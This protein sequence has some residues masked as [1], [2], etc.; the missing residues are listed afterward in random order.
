MRLCNMLLRIPV[1]F[2]LSF[3]VYLILL[4]IVI[5]YVLF[6]ALALPK[7]YSW[8]QE[9]KIFYLA[10]HHRSFPGYLCFDGILTFF[11]LSYYPNRR[12]EKSRWDLYPEE[13]YELTRDLI[14][15]RLLIGKSRPAVRELLGK[16]A[17]LLD[18]TDEW[19]FDL[20]Y[21]PEIGNIDPSVL[22]VIFKNNLVVRAEQIR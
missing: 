20:G 9:E 16:D 19:D 3:E 18:S 10:V 7:I 2:G 15:S 8:R 22:V 12:F 14:K 4:L 6:L 17:A 1:F 11:Y 21:K 13:R 5:P